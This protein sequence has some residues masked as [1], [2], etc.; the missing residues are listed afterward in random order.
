MR[1]FMIAAAGLAVA[2]IQPNAPPGVWTSADSPDSTSVAY[3]L[4]STDGER[5]LDFN[6]EEEPRH[7]R[8]DA[9]TLSGRGWTKGSRAT[10]ILA[11]RKFDAQTFI[12][13]A[14]GR[15]TIAARV[16]LSREV[17]AALSRPGAFGVIAKSGSMI[18]QVRPQIAGSWAPSPIDMIPGCTS[19]L[20]GDFDTGKRN[21]DDL[22]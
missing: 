1:L 7:L 12:I 10:V 6:C 2:A 18:A 5:L 8:I 17:L 22:E 20:R 4:K 13:G 19:S 15:P 14:P 16:P 9:N 11:G 21:D 3:R